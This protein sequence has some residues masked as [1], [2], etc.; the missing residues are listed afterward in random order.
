MKPYWLIAEY[1]RGPFYMGW[2]LYLRESTD[3]HTRNKN[4][5]WGWV[6]G[7]LKE[8]DA[9]KFLKGLGFPITGDGSTDA[10]GIA[11]FAAKYPI[12]GKAGGK[13]RGGLKVLSDGK[14][15]KLF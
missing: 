5:S 12:E 2:H 13:P 8:S 14:Q 7:K 11:K 10:D 1:C 9:G 4:G 15:V 3:F 6:R